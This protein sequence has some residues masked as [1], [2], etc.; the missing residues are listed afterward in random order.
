MSNQK[1]KT[2][3]LVD[4]ELLIAMNE[5]RELENE[6][7]RV[8]IARSGKE[9]IE[10]VDAPSVGIDLILMDIDLGRD[11]DGTEAAKM[12]LATHDIP[13]VFLSSH[14]ERNIVDK[15]EKI[16]SY[17]YVV[18]NT[19]ITV[20]SASIRMAF[21]LHEA[22]ANIQMKNLNI[23]SVNDDLVRSNDELEAANEELI[24]SHNEIL[25]REIALRESELMFRRVFDQSPIGMAITSTSYHFI[26]VNEAMC[27]M[28]GYSP[29][30]FHTLRFREI[31]HPD[32]LEGDIAQIRRL[33]SGEIDHY[34]TEKKYIRKD[35]SVIW[36]RLSLRGIRDN[37]GRIVFF[38]PMVQDITDNKSAE[39]KI[40]E[41]EE[42]YRTLFELESDAILL[43]DNE[44][45]RILSANRSAASLYGYT[46]EEL[47][48]LRNTDLS[49]QPEVTKRVTTETTIDPNAIIRI[50]IR[51]HRKKDG[52]VFPTEI[53]GRF[54]LNK[55]RPVHIAAIRDITDRKA[56]EENLQE[57]EDR[58][59][60]L[61]ESVTDYIY[62]VKIEDGR[63]VS[64]IHG[65]G[66]VGITGYSSG[67]YASDPELWYR[68]IHGDDRTTVMEQ[69]SRL[70]SEK[71]ASAVEHRIIHKNGSV[72]W[73]RN[74][75]VPHVDNRGRL[76]S[77]DGLISDITDRKIIE[78]ELSRSLTK[79][80]ILLKELQH[81]VKNNLTIISSLLSLEEENLSDPQSRQV[82]KDAISRIQS[83]TEIYQQF[84]VT[85][86]P[87]RIDLKKYISGMSH[88]LIEAYSIHRGRI[89][90]ELNLD[91]ACLEMKLAVPLGLILNELIT[92]ALKHAFPAGKKGKIAVE[93]KR[94]DEFITLAVS[95]DGIGIS[96]ANRDATAKG[97][98][99]RLVNE[100]ARQF[101]GVF[102]VDGSKGTTAYVRIKTGA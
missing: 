66:C 77:Y 24:Q 39:E 59:R 45:G 68:M 21:K 75:Q 67:E 100:L 74:A 63:P 58:Y 72:R 56:I 52:T 80:E 84:Y 26:R 47:L 94:T 96:E 22:Y 7:Y 64:T 69:A 42:L 43:I 93:L 20:L 91:D 14:N 31:T 73:V 53:T 33:E 16:T 6:G 27:R 11:M 61:V 29:D 65:P 50:P 101:G 49:D 99:T 79:N 54:F 34:V 32:Y 81:R 70:L 83:M 41:S 90:L 40:I 13:V 12:I 102:S 86:G 44:T 55:D 38:L 3:L 62:T 98:G 5:A 2:I 71:N 89:G 48:L 28:M 4:D 36:G 82:F 35:G 19:G 78:Q 18:K 10:K 57:S 88:K 15:T 87:D 76:L 60:R 37:D 17:G 85:G 95:D 23:K 1:N 25:D 9:A 97:F 46:V 30:E 92:N 8:I 51:Y